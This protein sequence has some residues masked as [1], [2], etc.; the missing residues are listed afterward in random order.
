V[1]D[2]SA[3]KRTKQ[4]RASELARRCYLFGR[5]AHGRPYAGRGDASYF[6]DSKGREREALRADL[7]DA[8]ETDEGYADDPPSDSILNA[9]IGDMRRAA[10]KCDRDPATPAEEADE[11]ICDA[12]W[13]AV[14]EHPE[15][16]KVHAGGRNPFDI[17]RE[18]A[19]YLLKANDP[20]R[21]FAMGPAA[22]V[23]LTET[24]K[25]DAFDQDGWLTYV[26][27]RVD[28]LSRTNDGDKIVAPPIAV[29]KIAA[30]IIL[31][32]LPQLDGVTSTPYL[33]AAGNLVASDGYHP[34]SRLVLRM[35]GLTLPPVSD[36]PTTAQLA[37]AVA[38]LTEDWL[39]DFPFATDADKANLV[40]ELLT[41]TGRE[42]FPLAPMFVHDASTAGSGKGLLLNTVS[43]IATGEPAEVM[44][45]PGDGDEQRKT[46]TS[47]LLSGKLLVAW[48]ELHVIAGR[49]LAAI[50]TAE[51]Y[52]GRILGANKLATVRNKLVQ[53]ALGNNVE[54]RGDMKRRVLPSRLVPDTEHPEH[55]TDF[56]HPDL[57]QWVREHRGELLAA[58]FTL[59]RN[60]L[61]KK[62]PQANVT[63][64]SFERWAR[65]IGGVLQQAGIEGFG[66]N[67]ADW[68]SYSED[69][70]GWPTHLRQL[71][72]RFGGGWFTVSDVA[73][74]VTAGYLKRPPLKRDPDKEVALQLAY[75]YRSQRERWYG[76]LRLVRSEG[77]D[78]AAGSYTWAVRR[79]GERNEDAYAE[80]DIAQEMADPSPVS[81]VSPE[82]AGQGPDR[83]TGDGRRR[84]GHLQEPARHL[85]ETASGISAGQPLRAEHAGDTGH[86]PGPNETGDLHA[87]NPAR[88]M[89]WRSYGITAVGD[90]RD[91]DEAFWASV[92]T[93]DKQPGNDSVAAIPLARAVHTCTGC[94]KRLDPALVAAGFSTHPNCGEDSAA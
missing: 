7:R 86:K 46:V 72:A 85:Q 33:D 15:R 73:D 91:A 47:V 21:L 3:S 88:A 50:L 67:T 57:L 84:P 35:D 54:V 81:S 24:G 44:E 60:W 64:G 41:I 28:F 16:L 48:D 76:E 92:A 26:A 80:N 52:S 87:Q 18:V 20:P 90:S 5:T 77:R 1:T 4:G 55:R 94:G 22:A 27:E 10:E 37:K 9:V 30:T 17:A 82:I 40:A 29:M 83:A 11:L 56:R 19:D 32:E 53:I 71:R 66:T 12:P 31:R 25:L 61:A 43:I 93:S 2:D 42:L 89:Q 14:D 51:V 49:T 70:S 6:L 23:L 39:S 69:D 36:K 58:A 75:A 74:A 59:W 34:G 63:M 62:W 65:T 45:L 68:L 38:L 8:W 78:S 13:E 79:R